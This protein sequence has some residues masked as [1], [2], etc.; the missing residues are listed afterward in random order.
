MPNYLSGVFLKVSEQI[1]AMP[2]LFHFRLIL[3]TKRETKS[4]RNGLLKQIG[5]GEE[6]IVYS[7][8]IYWDNKCCFLFQC[9]VVQC[10]TC[11][12]W[13]GRP[14]RELQPSVLYLPFL[15]TMTQGT[16]INEVMG[17]GFQLFWR[18]LIIYSLLHTWPHRPCE[19]NAQHNLSLPCDIKCNVSDLSTL[20]HQTFSKF[21]NT[22][23]HVYG[24]QVNSN[25]YTPRWI[26]RPVLYFIDIFNSTSDW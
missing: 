13:W 5:A 15:C 9:L 2:Y 7:F 21:T 10:C 25:F 17:S 14:R 20:I 23:M 1:N 8:L 16:I 22:Y 12:R 3:K 19:F 18:Y 11:S 6:W 26:S 24:M 4:I